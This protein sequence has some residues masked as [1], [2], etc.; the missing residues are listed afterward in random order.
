M[1]ERGKMFLR[2]PLLMVAQDFH[3][4]SICRETCLKAEGGFRKLERLQGLSAE[5]YFMVAMLLGSLVVRCQMLWI[6]EK[7]IEQD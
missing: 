2:V 6:Q 4:Q 7:K 3:I 5:N 1:Q